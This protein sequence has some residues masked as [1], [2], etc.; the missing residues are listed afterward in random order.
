MRMQIFQ[1]ILEFI[2]VIARY[3]LVPLGSGIG[4]A[5]MEYG[6]VTSLRKGTQNIAK[7]IA[8][9]QI[10]YLNCHGSAIVVISVVIIELEVAL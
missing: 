1:W 10:N 5:R 4:A 9:R 2:R 8:S 6:S 7:A 3:F